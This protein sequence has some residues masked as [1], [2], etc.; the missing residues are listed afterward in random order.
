MESQ[1]ILVFKNRGS[2]IVVQSIPCS[3]E[4]QG[5]LECTG[6]FSRLS[7]MLS[8]VRVGLDVAF[9]GWFQLFVFGRMCR[10]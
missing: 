5:H 9:C 7:W 2:I 1:Q 8:T 4:E 6:L 3:E 10:L